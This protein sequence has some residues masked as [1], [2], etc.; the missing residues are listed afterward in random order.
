L[1]AEFHGPNLELRFGFYYN[2]KPEEDP[3]VPAKNA[4]SKPSTLDDMATLVP[5]HI[6]NGVSAPI[7]IHSV[8]PHYDEA[9]FEKARAAGWRFGTPVIYLILDE[10]GVPTSV[11]L[12]HGYALPILKD[13]GKPTVSQEV[14]DILNQNAVD[15][16]KQYR[17]KP[18]MEDGKPVAVELNVTVN[19]DIF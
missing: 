12:A 11:E 3:A 17:F 8:E 15:A 10:E 13:D 1:P 4:E 9:A 5:K 18:A 7:L 19:V 16:I 14:L 2:L 6:G